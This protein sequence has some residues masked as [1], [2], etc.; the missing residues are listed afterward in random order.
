M[1]KIDFHIHTISTDRDADFDFSLESLRMYVEE[2]GLDAI[3]ITNHDVFDTEQFRSIEK[4]LDIPV[5]PGIEVSLNC[6]HLLIRGC[7]IFS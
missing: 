7:P 5:F 1:K 3:A 4:E 2:C 6:G